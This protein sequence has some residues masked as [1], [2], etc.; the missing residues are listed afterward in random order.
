MHIC[1]SVNPEQTAGCSFNISDADQSSSW[2]IVWPGICKYFGLEAAGPAQDGSLT[3]E[4]WVKS[5]QDRWDEWEKEKGLKTGIL[6]GTA[7]GFMTT[8]A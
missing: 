1:A 8:V 4:A 7:W 6:Q 3:G 2:E 5:Q